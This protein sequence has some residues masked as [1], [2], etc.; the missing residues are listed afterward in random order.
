MSNYRS[1]LAVF[2]NEGFESVRGKRVGLITNHTGLTKDFNSNVELFYQHPA[3]NLVALLG[4]EHGI[5]G[6]MGAG[7]QVGNGFDS[8]TGLPVYSLY[9]EKRKPTPEML[10]GIEVL[11]FDIQGI[12]VRFYTYISTL[13]YCMESCAENGLQLIVL[14]RLNPLGRRLEG[15]ILKPGYESFIG[16]YPIPQRHGMTAG[17]LALWANKEMQLDIE[18]EVIKTEGWNGQWFDKMNLLWVPPSPAIPDFRTTIIYP[19]TCLFSGTNI[20]NGRGTANPFELI[21]APWIDPY[22]LTTYLQEKELPG[23]IFRPTYFT[24]YSSKYKGEVCGGIQLYVV[25]R[26]VVNSY[27]TGLTILQALFI[28]Y[29]EKVQ[30][31]EPEKDGRYHFD[32]HMGNSKVREGMLNQ[33]SPSEIIASWEK[34]RQEFSA[35]RE[36]YLLY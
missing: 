14:D 15:N 19:V 35:L 31:R 36:R 27:L 33:K 16:L 3:I 5:Y 1:G 18:L 17:E 13:F 22:Q 10:E 20:S 4:P 21:G 2:I 8:Y 11:I 12:G 28:L 25:D 30:F 34:E 7:D 29:P 32:L 9:G 6:N 23:V 26:E 24:P